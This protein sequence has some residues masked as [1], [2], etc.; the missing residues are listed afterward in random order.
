MRL[1]VLILA[2]HVVI[3]AHAQQWNGSSTSA[4][5][6]HRP[7]VVGIGTST[8]QKIFEVSSPHNNYISVGSTISA[9]QFNGIHFGYLETNNVLYRKSALVFERTDAAA[10]GKIHFL[11]NDGVNDNSAA[12]ADAKL[13]IDYTGNVGI[14]ITAPSQRLDVNGNFNLT[15]SQRRIFLGVNGNFAAGIAAHPSKPDHGI[16]YNGGIE[17]PASEF[18][19]LAPNGN[20]SVGVINVYGNN[21]VGIGMINPVY[22]LD[23]NGSVHATS[24]FVNDQ[25]I[26]G[27]SQWT[28][29]PS[30]NIHF[31]TGNVGI[32]TSSPD[33]KLTV[34]GNIHAEEVI[35]DLEVPGPDYV[36]EENYELTPLS[37]VESYIKQNKHLPEV[38][39][40]KEMEA[41]GIRSGEM[42]MLLLKK[43]EELTLYV[44]ELERK[45]K[46]LEAEK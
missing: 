31:T 21:K 42:N 18:I 19:S 32:G 3:S 4:G 8:P 24:L 13:T 14:G 2:I 43:V 28:T 34:K 45:I 1:L 30:S 11:N 15:G 22:T 25:E 16:F 39:S 44:I 41:E 12:L 36:F 35:I 17:G 5:T 46:Q 20:Y 27:N 9:G 40:A 7:G 38:P 33:Q 10:R 6:I 26:T 23:V 37:E 29:S